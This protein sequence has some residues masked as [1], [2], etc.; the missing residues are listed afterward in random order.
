MAEVELVPCLSDNYA[1]L[2]HV[3]DETVLVD[4]PEPGPILATL[5]RRGWTLTTVLITHHHPD[6]VQALPDVR[7]SARVI[8][9]AGEADRISG[10]DET[11]DDGDA[12]SLG[13]INVLA[14][15]TPGHTSGPISFHMPDEGIA[16]T[17]DTLFAMGCGRLFEGTAETMW[18]S[19]QKLRRLLPDETQIYCGHEY[20]ETNARFATSVLPDDPAIAARAKTVREARA[21]GEPTVPTTMALEKATNPFM[22]SDDP[23]VAAALGMMGADPAEV[24]AKLR[25]GRD[26]F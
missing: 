16:F 3:A 21:R 19:F 25:A 6:H 20:T 12:F 24:F 8:G 7:G 10:L 2:V 5:D 4:A 15:S 14:I 13:P 18:T 1:V 17:A 23:S 11:V 26:T 9:T 22:R